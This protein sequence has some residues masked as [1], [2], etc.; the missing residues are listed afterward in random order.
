VNIKALIECTLRWF[1][2]NHSCS[3]LSAKNL[4]ETCCLY[5]HYGML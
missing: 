1:N 3:S 4:F 5:F 2:V